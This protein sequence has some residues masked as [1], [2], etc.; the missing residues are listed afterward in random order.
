M[1]EKFTKT[2]TSFS[3]ADCIVRVNHKIVAE[4]AE[5]TYKKDIQAF[6]T[7]K[8]TGKIIA[9]VFDRNPLKEF[10][11]SY[12]VSMTMI[13]LD[14]EGRSKAYHFEGVKLLN[15]EGGMSI[16]SV[17]EEKE[18]EFEA[19]RMVELP[20]YRVL[21]KEK[22]DQ[23][24]FYKNQKNDD[25]NVSTLIKVYEGEIL[26]MVETGEAFIYQSH[27]VS[28]LRKKAYKFDVMQEALEGKKEL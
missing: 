3:G 23:L 5:V 1:T 6:G 9:T 26:K 2:I 21:L 13:F 19:T 20:N 25:E 7:G 15:E 8:V 18:Y 27:E 24:R 28:E 4:I 11:N 22:L 17:V 16:D 14:E 12:S 10:L